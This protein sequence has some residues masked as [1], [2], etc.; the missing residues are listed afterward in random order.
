MKQKIHVRIKP[1]FLGI[2]LTLIF[3]LGVSASALADFA[4]TTGGR[5]YL[6]SSSSASSSSLGLYDSGTWVEIITKGGSW[7]YVRTEDNKYGYMSTSYLLVDY[8]NGTLSGTIYNPNGYVNLRGS[9]SMNGNIMG[10]YQSGT[11]VSVLGEENGWYHVNVNNMIGYMVKDF[12]RVNSSSTVGYVR[13]LYGSKV[14]L[15]DAPRTSAGILTSVTPGTEVTVIRRGNKWHKIR[16]NGIV[17]FM[18]ASYISSSSGGSSSSGRYAVVN[19][20]RST[21]VLNL[22][23][24]ASTNA[25]VL[26]Y[27]RNGTQV[28][29]VSTSGGWS[30]VYVGSR[31]GYMMSQ[32]LSYTSGSG[33]SSSSTLYNP[34]GNS[35]VNMRSRAS[36][37][38]PVIGVY[39][40][41]TTVNI[42]QSGTDWTKVSIGSQIGYISTHFIRK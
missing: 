26:G 22:R 39:Q 32:Y 29:V 12:I 34:N 11:S 38:A 5:L 6:R 23:E 24:T 19:N 14:N 2:L 13:S 37:Y 25:R 41:G 9:A 28:K 20:P 4:I 30:E 7:H 35:I 16:A 15:R 40:V 36:L 33:S 17:G 18:D 1:I 10:S 8:S 21:Q 31:H 3:S 27:Y 42:L